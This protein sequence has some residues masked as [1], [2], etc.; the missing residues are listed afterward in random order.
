MNITGMFAVLKY[1]HGSSTWIQ[2]SVFAVF[3]LDRFAELGVAEASVPESSSVSK[4]ELC[5]AGTL[6][7]GSVVTLIYFFW[8]PFI[9][10]CSAFLFLRL[11]WIQFQDHAN[12]N[13]HSRYM[14]S[15]VFMPIIL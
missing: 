10:F 15:P 12:S 4:I 5:D 9:S 2:P 7:A 11:G 3:Y 6:L 1:V 8:F 14:N 13:I